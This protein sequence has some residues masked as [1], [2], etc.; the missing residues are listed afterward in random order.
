MRSRTPATVVRTLYTSWHRVARFAST[1]WQPVAAPAAACPEK[2]TA[3]Q[4][5]GERRSCAQK[6]ASGCEG[7]SLA[8]T[9]AKARGALSRIRCS[10]HSL[11]PTCAANAVNEPRKE[12]SESISGAM[13]SARRR[14]ESASRARRLARRRERSRSSV[15]AP[16]YDCMRATVPD[17][18]VSFSDRS[19]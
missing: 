4:G 14:S 15:I 5:A 3:G 11:S 17:D 9:V 18:L 12:S 8:G 6:G 2:N 19:L 13:T 7:A 16:R 10:V 1:Y